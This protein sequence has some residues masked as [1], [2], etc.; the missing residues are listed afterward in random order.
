MSTPH[1]KVSPSGHYQYRFVVPEALRGIVGKREIK[2]SLGKDR[3]RALKMYAQVE[4]ETERLLKSVKATASVDASDRAL[5]IRKMRQFGFTEK[6]INTVGGHG[7]ELSDRLDEG[8]SIFQDELI[9]EYEDAEDRGK[10]PAVSLE[11]IR[12][13]GRKRLPKD[14]YTVASALTHYL[15]M[16]ATGV[17]A[18]DL[19][20]TNRVN[21]VK[22]RLIAVIGKH[23]VTKRP[24]EKL[25]RAEARKFRDA[26]ADEM[27]PPSVKRTIEIVSPAINKMIKEHDLDM[28]NPFAQLE[29]KGATNSRDARLPLSEDDMTALAPTM[30]K[31]D[32]SLAALWVVLRDTGAR[33]GEVCNLRRM[34]VDEASRCM[35][36]R[37]YGDHT[38]KTKNS[39]R[40]VPLSPKALEV[41]KSLASDLAPEATL[42]KRYA[43]PRRSEKASAALMKRLRTVVTDTKKTIHSLR[44]R[45]KDLLRNTDCPESLAKEIMGHSEAG[46]AFNYGAGYALNV[47]RAALEKAW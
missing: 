16:K 12:A 11:A 38:L 28:K 18:R 34:D 41:L 27:A 21:K 9:T 25:T 13:I 20:L 22:E 37:P 30:E 15:T 47:K 4:R 39:E 23:E 7:G 45:M 31:G 2:K 43:G 33:L 1:L 35:R 36:I 46:V 10:S 5:I 40:D 26:L 24:L 6:D 44:H 8:L 19:A 29:I 14:T 3:T 32:A 42:F 17:H